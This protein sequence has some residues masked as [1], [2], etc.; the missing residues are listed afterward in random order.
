MCH[1][2]SVVSCEEK[3]KENKLVMYKKLINNVSCMNKFKIAVFKRTI[4][5][6][7]DDNKL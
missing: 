1:A 6:K 7:K 2:S 3:E 5:F 4:V